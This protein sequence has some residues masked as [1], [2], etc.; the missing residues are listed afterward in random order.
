MRGRII[1]SGCWDDDVTGLTVE[2][3]LEYYDNDLVQQD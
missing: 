1:V 2:K 3:G